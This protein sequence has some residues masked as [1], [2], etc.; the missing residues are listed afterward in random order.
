[1]RPPTLALD[2]DAAQESPVHGRVIFVLATPGTGGEQ[3]C[4]ALGALPGA[5][6]APVPTHVFSHGVDRILEH[7]RLDPGPQAI[8]GLAD[9]QPFLLAT[10]LLADTPFAALLDKTSAD[11]VVEYSPD[12]IKYADEIAGLYPDATLVHVVRDGRQVAVRLSSPV[13]GLSRR[14]SAKRWVDDQR[15]MIDVEH[16]AVFVMRMEG[17]VREPVRLVGTLADALGFDADDKAI[18][19]AAAELGTTR[20]LPEVPTGRAGAIV[21]IVGPDLLVH[22]DYSTG[23]ASLPQSVAAWGDLISYGGVGFARKVGADVGRRTAARAQRRRRSVA[24]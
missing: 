21:E 18:E 20:T 9:L 1:M 22:H 13:H 4:R 16:P 24:R 3:V 10:R 23:A 5:V 14:E 19:R 8:S 12:H 6:A 11:V 2:A 7:W 17:L 15:L